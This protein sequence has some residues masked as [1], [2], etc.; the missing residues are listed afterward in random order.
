MDN[1]DFTLT[2][3][4][5]ALVIWGLAATGLCFYIN[6]KLYMFRYATQVMIG[7][8]ANGDIRFVKNADGSVD[9]LMK[10]DL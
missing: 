6:N 9:A 8:V 5:F 2:M 10:K 7:H 4:E 3:F 1:L